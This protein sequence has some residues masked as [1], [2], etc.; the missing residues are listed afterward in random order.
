M[1][2]LPLSGFELLELGNVVFLPMSIAVRL[3]PIRVTPRDNAACRYQGDIAIPHLRQR[4]R[5]WRIVPNLHR[6]L[7]NK[8][9]LLY[10][11]EQHLD[12]ALHS[13]AIRLLQ[14]SNTA[15]EI[16]FSL[17]GTDGFTVSETNRKF[18][19]AL[20]RVV[21]TRG[22]LRRRQTVDPGVSKI[23]I[24]ADARILLVHRRHTRNS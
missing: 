2:R 12:G 16:T 8:G 9:L 4:R 13:R 19:Q 17:R 18:G 10:F 5:R 14:T 3:K 7:A 6:Q 1:N 15:G 21:H 24:S 23:A 22:A 11:L 20:Q